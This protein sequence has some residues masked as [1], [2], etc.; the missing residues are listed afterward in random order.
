M[1]PVM[2]WTRLTV[3]QAAFFG[4]SIVLHLLLGMFFVNHLFSPSQVAPT[5]KLLDDSLEL[6]IAETESDIPVDAPE[7]A[8]IAPMTAPPLPTVAPYLSDATGELALAPPTLDIPPPELPLLLEETL[9]EML[10][11]DHSNQLTDLPEITLPP[12]EEVSVAQ[13]ATARFETPQLLTD[14]QTQ[15][16]KHYPRTA[17]E[18]RWEGAVQLK[19]FV[20]EDGSVREVSILSSSGYRVLDQNARA[21]MRKARYTSGPAELTQTIEYKL[22]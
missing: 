20:A 14:I 5:P 2:R 13:G 18:R 19:I 12:A 15:L 8:P 1:L 17:R 7:Q 22:K 21:M 16:R 11:V 3:E 4:A 10:P 9:P 6:I